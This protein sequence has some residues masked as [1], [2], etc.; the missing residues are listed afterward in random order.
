MKKLRTAMG[1]FA[2]LLLLSISTVPNILVTPSKACPCTSIKEVNTPKPNLLGLIWILTHPDCF[3]C[4]LGA[5]LET[6]EMSIYLVLCVL[7]VLDM[8]PGTEIIPCA[9]AG[10]SVGQVYLAWK[11]CEDICGSPPGD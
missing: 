5:L 1:L 7:T 6:T 10:V 9:F 8:M 3:D 11:M 2:I 4:V